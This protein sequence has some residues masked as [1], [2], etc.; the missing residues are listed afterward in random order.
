MAMV[1]ILTKDPDARRFFQLAWEFVSKSVAARVLAALNHAILTTERECHAM[2]A[3]RDK[4]DELTLGTLLEHVCEKGHNIYIPRHLWYPASCIAVIYR[5]ALPPR[6]NFGALAHE[7]SHHIVYA[8]GALDELIA[9]LRQDLPVVDRIVEMGLPKGAEFH[10]AM[11]IR[12]LAEEGAAACITE[13]YFW[14]LETGPPRECHGLMYP[15]GVVNIL[16][17]LRNAYDECVRAGREDLAE[18]IAEQLVAAIKGAKY[19]NTL[20]KV[21]EIARRAFAK[22]PRDVYEEDRERYEVLFRD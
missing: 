15:Y 18:M 21:H 12:R 13:N 2:V 10:V 8:L 9:A 6:Y 14:R 16:G 3:L 11:A 4:I 5:D 7:V 20:G 19:T 22:W 17:E 1:H